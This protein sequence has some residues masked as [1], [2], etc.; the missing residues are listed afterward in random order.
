M[1]VIGLGGSLDMEKHSMHGNDRLV[2]DGNID[3]MTK[4]QCGKSMVRLLFVACIDKE[5]NPNGLGDM[6][7]S[8]K[9]L[10]V[11]MPASLH[12]KSFCIPSLVFKVDIGPP[13]NEL[14]RAFSKPHVA[15]DPCGQSNKDSKVV[16]PS[17][18]PTT[19]A[20]NNATT[21]PMED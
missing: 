5:C 8:V 14:V 13:T 17:K 6:K 21:T 15:H 4:L 18:K 19:Y 16:G 20:F 12:K 11:T 3:N 1:V 7:I 10:I 2:E 9:D